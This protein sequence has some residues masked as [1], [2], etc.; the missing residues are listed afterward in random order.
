MLVG[1]RYGVLRTIVGVL[2]AVL[3]GVGAGAA[4]Q[5]MDAAGGTATMKVNARLVVLDVTVFDR[6]GHFVPNLDRSEF[7]V[8]EDKVAQKIRN[9]EVPAEHSMPAAASAA[10]M[11]RSSADLPKIGSAPVNVL[12]IDELNTPFPQIAHAQQSMRHFL[13]QQP[14]KLAVPTL[15][16]AAGASR[17]TV[18]HDFTQSRADLL[19]SIKT[20][21]TEADFGA[22]IRALNGGT[23]GHDDG[24]SRTL[25]ALAQIASSLRGKPGHKNVIWVGSGY[26]AMLDL[27]GMSEADRTKTLAGIRLVTDRMLEAR[28]TLYTVDPAGAVAPIVEDQ[29]AELDFLN[30]GQKLNFGAAE[31]EMSFDRLAASTGGAAISGRNDL[32]RVVKSVSTEGAQYY[33]LAYTPSSTSVDERAYRRVLVTMKNPNMR[34][35]TRAGYYAGTE[36]VPVVAPN[37]VKKQPQEIRFDLLSAART[38]M[39]YGGLHI[40]ARP[41]PSG[42]SLDVTAQDL[43]WQVQPDESRLADVTVLAVMFDARGKELGQHASQMKERL[44]STD[45]VDATTRVGFTVPLTIAPR[46]AKIRFVMRDAATGTLG[47]ADVTR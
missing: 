42:Y 29:N 34:A 2:G 30:G 24:F 47:S 28:M 5:T 32:D 43:R 22:M 35:V 40:L 1:M 27:V 11:V 26:N 44:E 41:I 12:V 45:R 39:V 16:V 37:T 14:E 46:T 13:E 19:A 7:I 31:T 18:L 9:F 20:H 6:Y 15:F 3:F 36:P 10:V 23:P 25:G 17:I 4:A 21:V 33:T 8:T 38:T